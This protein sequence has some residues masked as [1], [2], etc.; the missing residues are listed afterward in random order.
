M[1][2]LE[3]DELSVGYGNATVVR[4]VSLCVEA[5][6]VVAMIGHNGAGKS[7]I[8]KGIIGLLKARHGQVVLD[9][10]PVTR[11]ATA[12]RVR[13]GM[14]LVA[15]GNNTFADMSVSDNLELSVRVMRTNSRERLEALDT[16]YSLFP[17]LREKGQQK[18]GSL[19]GGQ[20]QMLAIGLAL[21]KSPRVLLLD[22]P[23][24]G[25]AP[26][27]VTRVFASLREINET[28]GTTI[29]LVEQN[30]KEALGIASRAYVIHTGSVI[31]S[32]TSKEIASRDDLFTLV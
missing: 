1:A 19:S 32:G 25:L 22:E 18:A 6:E 26:V 8:L 20:R 23:T 7:S 3:V 4:D 27:M 17:I 16:I 10:K 15:Q 21:A 30:I 11:V 2:L 24:V 28:F 9:G 5:G 14:S 12:E 13:S 31:I 29:L